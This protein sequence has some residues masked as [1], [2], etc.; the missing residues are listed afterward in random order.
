MRKFAAAFA[1][2][3]LALSLAGAASADTIFNNG[4]PNSVGGN[5]ATG[6]VQAEDFRFRY[7]SVVD[8]AG[9]YIG[10]ADGLENF[11]GAL[12]YYI[13]SD[14][15]GAPGT[16]LASGDAEPTAIDSGVNWCCGGNAFLFNFN[17]ASAFN[18]VA[19]KTYW[20]GFHLNQ[21]FERADLYWVTTGLEQAPVAINRS[22]FESQNGTF[23][24]WEGNLNEHAFQIYG[25]SGAPEPAAWALMI[26]GFG[27]AGAALRRR[28]VVAA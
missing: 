26:L 27:A 11:D 12:Q 23:D 15:D 22:G 3:G 19:G 9:V 1:G 25:T 5:E 10:G 24:N 6:W 8:G 16:V 18:A 2:L 20:L 14:A 4:G 7:D 13:L 28:R 17:F 21:G